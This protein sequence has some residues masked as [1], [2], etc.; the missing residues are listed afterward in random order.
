M[1]YLER[2]CLDF[3]VNELGFWVLKKEILESWPIFG[4]VVNLPICNRDFVGCHKKKM[5]F[6]FYQCVGQVIFCEVATKDRVQNC[7]LQFSKV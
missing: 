3:K 2:G 6:P 7:T 4:R 5:N 1:S